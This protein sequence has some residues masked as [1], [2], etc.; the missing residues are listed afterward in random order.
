MITPI[1]D[2]RCSQRSTTASGLLT[3]VSNHILRSASIP[4][5]ISLS[6]FLAFSASSFASLTAL[7]DSSAKDTS[8]AE[9]ND[10]ILFGRFATPAPL[11]AAAFAPCSTLPTISSAA[12]TSFSA[13]S[14][15]SAAF[16]R[17]SASRCSLASRSS[18]RFWSIT[19]SRATPMA[20]LSL[21]SFSL[22]TPFPVGTRT[23]K[24]ASSATLDNSKL[25]SPFAY[26]FISARLSIPSLSTS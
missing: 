7:S 21:W 3:F 9:V 17:I 24:I 5:A 14:S 18:L 6:A 23:L 16:L 12:F 22:G 1:F 26:F 8:S 4:V 19:F 20:T 11:S 25:N 15:C 10:C 2:K 13:S